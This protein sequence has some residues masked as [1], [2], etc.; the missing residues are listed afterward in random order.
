MD[1]MQDEGKDKVPNKSS[2]KKRKWSEDFKGKAKP[3]PV[4]TSATIDMEMINIHA[5]LLKRTVH[6]DCRAAGRQG[7]DDAIERVE[8]CALLF[9]AARKGHN[10]E[11]VARQLM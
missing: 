4:R 10:V 2:R 5:Q 3:V 8:K 11:V 1:C 6:G 9:E 7:L